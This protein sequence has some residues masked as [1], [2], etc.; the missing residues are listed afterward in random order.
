MQSV[1]TQGQREKW[2]TVRHDKRESKS[3]VS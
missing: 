3:K 2:V 1:G